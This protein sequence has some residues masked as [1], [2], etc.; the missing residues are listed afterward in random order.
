MKDF[1]DLDKNYMIRT[2]NHINIGKVSYI[3][4]GCVVIHPACWI[5]DT[6]RFHNCLRDG[7]I[8]EVEPFVN[9]VMMS[10]NQMVDATEWSHELPMVQK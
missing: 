2:V 7:S 4:D 9:P 6:G 3:G 5:A 1:F 10:F 8:S